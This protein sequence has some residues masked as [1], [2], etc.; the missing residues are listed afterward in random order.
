MI[1]CYYAVGDT[2]HVVYESPNGKHEVIRTG[3]VDEFGRDS[4]YVRIDQDG[5]DVIEVTGGGEV[6]AY[7]S[8][9]HLGEVMKLGKV[10][11]THDYGDSV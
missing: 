3:T 11:T 6:Y 4:L 2:V 7:E 1:G 8:G 9:R 10:V 5:P